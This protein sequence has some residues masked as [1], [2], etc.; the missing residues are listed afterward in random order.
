MKMNKITT[1]SI[2]FSIIIVSISF[3]FFM[4]AYITIYDPDW[5]GLMNFNKE[6]P[7][8][9]KIF[10]LG[11]SSAYAVSA[12]LINEKLEEQG[13][14]F[15]FY[16][17]ADM[18]DKPQKRLKNIQN[19]LNKDTKLILYGI[20]IYDFEIFQSKLESTPTETY[21]L[22]P[23]LFFKF[24]FEELINNNLNEQFPLSP[25]DRI[26]TLVKYVLRGS[27]QHYH[28]FIKFDPTP[29]NDFNTNEKL[30]GQPRTI[31]SIDV[32]TKNPQ[33]LA[34]NEII[35]KCQ[36]QGIK[37]ILFTN[38]NSKLLNQGIA[39]ADLQKF[40]FFMQEI[41]K[42]DDLD[43]YFL[44]NE[45]SELNIWKDALHI[46]IH[47]NASIFTNDISEILLDELENNAV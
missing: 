30:Y 46:A 24:S 7:D 41:S 34:L 19:I 42:N 40:E 47:P 11:S 12:T 32:S 31:N 2:I 27:D 14:D 35:S 29:I 43:V 17:L 8:K 13:F 44:H 6:I 23:H 28:P 37:L 45:Y 1:L 15:E 21:L 25:K 5:Y 38:P 3:S 4:D 9:E 26:L 18:S 39:N 22:D 10:L 36:N 20:G 16:N 33:I